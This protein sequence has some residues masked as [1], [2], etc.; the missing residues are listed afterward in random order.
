[1]PGAA[2]RSSTRGGQML[3]PGFID[4]HVHFI[5]GGF[6]LSPR[7]AARR[8]HARGV[9]R[10]H[11]GVR[12]D[13]AAGHLDHRTATGTTAV[14]RRAAA[15]AS[16]STRS[17]R[18]IRCG[19]TGSMGTWR[20]PTAPRCGRGRHARD[21][22]TSRAAR[23]CAT[24][25]ASRPASSRTTRWRSSI[26]RCRPPAA[27]CTTARSTRRCTTSPSRRD[28]RAQH[29]H[30]GTTSTFSSARTRRGRL[31]TRIYA[32]VPLADVGA[33]ARHASAARRPR[34]RLA[35]HRRRSRVS[36]TARSARTP[37][38]CSSRSPMRRRTAACSSTSPEDLY[39]WTSGADKAGLHVM[40]HAIGDRA[41]RMQ[42]DIYERVEQ[43]ERR[44]ATA[45]SA[46]STRSTSRRRTSRASRALGVIASM[47]PYHAIDDGRWAE[48]GHRP[49]ARRRRRTRSARCSTPARDSRSA[50]TGSSRRRRRSK[51]STPPSRDARS[52]AGIPDGWVPEQKITVEEALRAYTSG[53]AYASFEEKKGHAGAGQARR[54]RAHRPRP[55]AH[56]ARAD[57]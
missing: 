33:A 16:G 6:R 31:T 22:A 3:V 17:R 38:R 30:R 15:R 19:S 40:V 49:R 24:R 2:R 25:T 20:S 45:A 4:A 50:A 11:R 14:G 46:S 28:V 21:A 52:T 18:T 44:R 53:S 12:E 7:A 48:T 43:G 41:I 13:G 32:A 57:S 51:A 10:A 55:D 56:P 1:M 34:R 9:R 39:E 42:L 23:S 54:L 5:D 36:S 29:G 8:A 35:A 26:G 47:Q 37:R 27:S